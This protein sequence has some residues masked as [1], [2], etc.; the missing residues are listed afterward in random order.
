[1]IGVTF[2]CTNKKVT[3]EIVRGETL[4]INAPSPLIPLP[5]H[6]LPP[7]ETRKVRTAYLPDKL[8]FDFSFHIYYN[9]A[10][11]VMKWQD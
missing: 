8:K 1:M 2:L 5:P 6:R 10:K 11:E 9:G 4:R 3:K 7:A